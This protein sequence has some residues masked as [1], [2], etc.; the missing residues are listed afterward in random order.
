MKNGLTLLQRLG[1]TATREKI[2]IDEDLLRSFLHGTV[3]RPLLHGDQAMLASA[4][5]ARNFVEDEAYEF[6]ATRFSL[7]A[8]G[9]I[10]LFRPDTPVRLHRADFT[11]GTNTGSP[12]IVL[13]RSETMALRASAAPDADAEHFYSFE[14]FTQSQFPIPFGR[15]GVLLTPDKPFVAAIN[16]GT[17]NSCHVSMMFS[18]AQLTEPQ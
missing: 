5:S 10:V 17:V 3:S 13:G 6:R 18:D 9:R 2:L 16:V 1:I 12:F 14:A 8:A 15:K 7:G 11:I 4:Q